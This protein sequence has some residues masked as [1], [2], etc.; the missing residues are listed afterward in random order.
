MGTT[1]TPKIPA[2]SKIQVNLST[3]KTNSYVPPDK[4]SVVPG[5]MNLT[6]EVIDRSMDQS[7]ELNSTIP[8][9]ELKVIEQNPVIPNGNT[10]FGGLQ[11]PMTSDVQTNMISD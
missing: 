4:D 7:Q 2:G 3:E 5:E 9:E 11:S 10:F 8:K 6:P 1:L